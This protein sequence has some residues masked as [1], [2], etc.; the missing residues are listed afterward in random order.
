LKLDQRG[1]EGVDEH[2]DH[3]RR[4]GEPS[5]RRFLRAHQMLGGSMESNFR[6][7]S[8]VKPPTFLLRLAGL[9]TSTTRFVITYLN[10]L[11]HGGMRNIG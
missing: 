2:A 6:A 1:G 10:M 11:Q 9:A 8:L 3:R 7:P 4:S 5:R